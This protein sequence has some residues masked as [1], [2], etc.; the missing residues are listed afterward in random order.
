[1][2]IHERRMGGTWQ[3]VD[4]RVQTST[5]GIGSDGRHRIAILS[6][7]KKGSIVEGGN[8]RGEGGFGQNFANA[9]SI[10]G[11]VPCK[12]WRT[13]MIKLKEKINSFFHLVEER[14]ELEKLKTER[15]VQEDRLKKIVRT[16]IVKAALDGEEGWFLK[17]VEDDPSCV[18]RVVNECSSKKEK[19]L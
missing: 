11:T 16:T 7:D 1:M 5:G 18:L 2:I 10:R 6:S 19:K 13:G 14:K 17:L 12:K 8:D 3:G 9:N 15:V 4:R